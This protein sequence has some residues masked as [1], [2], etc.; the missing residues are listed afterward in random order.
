VIFIRLDPRN[1]LLPDF[2]R[3][4]EEFMP[5]TIYLFVCLL[6]IPLFG[7]VARANNFYAA[8]AGTP[9]GDGSISSPWDL[10]TALNQPASMQPGD[11]IW[12][13]GGVYHSNSSSGFSSYL[14]GTAAS[15]IIV[16]NYN[17]E[18]AALEASTNAFV[19]GVYGSYTW[20]WGLEM[21]CAGISRSTSA[22]GSF[23]NPMAFG[24]G[25]Y[26]PGNR[27]INNVVH[28]TA[29][30]F[31]AYD[32]APNTEFYGNLSYYNGWMAS[33]R[34]HGH[35]IYMQ[36]STGTKLISDNLVGDNADEGIQ[37]YGS[38]TASLVG[39][40][41]TGNTLYN[42]SSWPFPH[43]Q[44]NLVVGG[45]QTQQ[46]NT[47]TN[48]YSFFTPS[49]NYGFVNLGQYTMG[50]NLIATGNVFAGGYVTVAVEGMAGPFTFTGN[51]VYNSPSSL[52]LITLGQFSGQT[53]SGYT[54]DNNAYFGLNNF[55][56]GTY[57]GNVTVNGS[58][59]DLP[60]WRAATGFDSHSTFTTA[61]SGAWVYVRPNKYEAKRANIT[62]YNWDL[63]PTVSVDLSSVLSF[64]DQYAIQDAQ[65]FF[66]PPV[67]SGT[68][69][70]GAVAI[71]TTLTA[72]STPVGFSAPAHTGPLLITL[73]VMS[74]GSTGP[75]AGVTISPST[76]TVQVGSTL[77]FSSSTT[78]LASTQVIW[79]A[80]SGT[81]SQT[82]AYLAPASAG[83]DIVTATSV[84]DPTKSASASVIVAAI[85]TPPTP[86]PAGVNFNIGDSVQVLA[87]LGSAM[88]VR[89]A[90]NTSQP[91]IGVQ[92]F[93]PSTVGVVISA[94]TQDAASPS[95]GP[96][97]QVTWNGGLDN[98]GNPVTTMTGWS[99][100][101]YMAKSTALP[102]PTA[103]VETIVPKTNWSLAYVDSQETLCE[104]GFASNSFDNNTSTYWH[105][106]Y[107]P[108]V[109]Q[110]PH[111]IQIDLGTAYVVNGF[112]YLP[113]QDG[114]THG[115]IGQYEFYA[116]NDLSN[117]GS[118]LATGTFANDATEKQV[119]FTPGAYRYVRLRA[120][121][122]ANGGPWTSMAELTLLQSTPSVQALSSISISPAAPTINVGSTQQLVA[123]GAYP[124]GST[125][126]LSS[127]ASWNSSASA[128]TVTST[129]LVTGQSAG[130][131]TI[132]AALNGVTGNTS[133]T[134]Q[135][136]APPQLTAVPKNNWS[137]AYVDS[138][139]TQ[140]ENGAATN[141]FDA[142]SV[143][144]WHT[145]YCVT[146]DQLPHEIQIDMG[147]GYVLQ[148]FRYLPR[149]DGGTHGR[150]GQFEFYATNDLS[151][152]GAPLATG[153]FA[154]DATEKQVLFA[155]G[156]YRFIRL[157]AL[158]EAEGGPWTSM[159]ELTA[160]Q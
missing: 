46:N 5:K 151:N 137:L 138:Q 149:Q 99:L 90:P 33:D 8:P 76:A 100:G 17:G 133:V 113:R 30:G 25:V 21:R 73:V 14:V 22:S 136:A 127:L 45:G 35:G 141:G 139:E 154:D 146:V 147:T 145:A 92:P 48:N 160:L 114:G 11:T 103:P 153:S 12:L 24:V 98:N 20:F 101:A 148:G 128:A 65:N 121:T 87:N 26:G 6:A 123:T 111:E 97:Y 71:P 63:T 67:M 58:Y 62:I 107:C 116:T 112:R 88:G 104:N 131:A 32:S 1:Y 34:N 72:K 96:M 144:I 43:F 38:G 95:Q 10:D 140:C 105:T 75:P 155:P 23:S 124:D 132:S 56:Y 79:A 143:T 91:R 69:A 59:L 37:I 115:R 102:P 40:T 15:P 158:S 80:A 18:Q 120:L 9:A 27:M 41:V 126:D 16:R 2:A 74:V 108:A 142:S 55:Y 77:Q 130:T 28:D 61:P 85:P 110:L 125:Q 86:P 42:T 64:G 157:R 84:T 52:R 93:P 54:W 134:I 150:I 39:I 156:S 81:I 51:N 70:G 31:S 13:R 129:G 152:W 19:L 60:G 50:S 29:Q 53:L 82:G 68:Y 4:G 106:A 44:Y 83:T 109:A 7:N 117:W 36:N 3:R 159:A 57:N 119:L 47:V 89:A 66:G 135:T 49:Q 78:G 94:A 118:P 122:E